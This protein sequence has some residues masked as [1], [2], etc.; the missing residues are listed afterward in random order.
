MVIVKDNFL[1]PK[2]FEWLKQIASSKAKYSLKIAERANAP[3]IAKFYNAEKTAW[4]L[5]YYK[6][7]GDLT[8]PANGIGKDIISIVDDMKNFLC[9][10]DSAIKNEE[11]INLTFMFAIQGYSVP[12]HIDIRSPSSTTEDLSKI[13]KI[14]LFCHEEWS[15]KWGGELCFTKGD[16][17]PLPNRLIIYSNDEPHWVKPVK[18]TKDI[19]IRK[20]FGLRYREE[21]YEQ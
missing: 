21:K 7:Y 2:K 16:F 11:L 17:L 5:T 18:D 19:I 10:Y 6:L 1:P 14:F 20:I 15:D 13:Y 8:M 9:G 12:R 4:D 3:F